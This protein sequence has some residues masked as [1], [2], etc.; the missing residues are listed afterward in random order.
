MAKKQAQKQTPAPA[1]AKDA[2]THSQRGKYVYK[3]IV[4]TIM[5]CACGGKFVKTRRAQVQCLRCI[6]EN[7]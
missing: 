3:P 6:R 2:K 1:P 5:D 7:E 4:S